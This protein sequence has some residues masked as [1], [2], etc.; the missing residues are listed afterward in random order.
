MSTRKKGKSAYKVRAKS[1]LKKQTKKQGEVQQYFINLTERF[2]SVYI[3]HNFSEDDEAVLDA[4]HKHNSEWKSYARSI[5]GK[6]LN[7]YNT[8]ARRQQ[9][10]GTFERFV[11][12]LISKYSMEEKVGEGNGE[13][14]LPIEA[15]LNEEA[16]LTEKEWYDYPVEDIQK[17]LKSIGVKT[18]AKTI[19]GLTK[20]V[21]DLVLDYR[22]AF[23]EKLKS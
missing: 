7:V 21:D 19:K 2:T 11:D 12:K 5:I 23:I 4:F 1:Q 20:V 9:F 16:T 17:A 15:N 6:N 22:K 18:T 13:E 8:K 10:I 3:N 14:N